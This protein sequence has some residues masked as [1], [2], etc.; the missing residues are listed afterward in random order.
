MMKYLILSMENFCVYTMIMSPTM[1]NAIIGGDGDSM[2]RGITWANSP[3]YARATDRDWFYKGIWQI[4]NT[5]RFV[6]VNESK[7]SATWLAQRDLLRM[8]QDLFF[9]W[10]THLSNSLVRVVRHAWEHFDVTALAEIDKCNPETGQYSWIIEE[11]ARIINQPVE[12]AFKELK[13]RIESDNNVRFRI[14][15]MGEKW[16]N[17]INKVASYADADRVRKEMSREFWLNSLI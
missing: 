14:Q 10:D 12:K 9:A 6:E 17:E 1:A 8:R 13:L 5:N 4:D 7:V 15:A 3:E 16:K 11:Y 2:I